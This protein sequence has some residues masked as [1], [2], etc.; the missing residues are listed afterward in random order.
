QPPLAALDEP[1]RSAA[2]RLRAE[3]ARWAVVVST[4]GDLHGWASADALA[5]AGARGTVGDAARRMEAWVPLGAPLK[6]AFSE[7]LQHDAG[8]VAVVDGARFVGVLTPAKLHEA[9]RR[10]VDADQRGVSRD[11]VDFD[12][13]SDA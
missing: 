2:A 3:G 5:G 6:K 11:E 9:L 8:W 10:S 1:A 13:V 4:R 12:S 7:M